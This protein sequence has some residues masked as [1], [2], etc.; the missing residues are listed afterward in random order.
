M[1]CC[2]KRVLVS[3]YTVVSLCFCHHR[4]KGVFV[5]IKYFHVNKI[6]YSSALF[7]WKQALKVWEIY[8]S[9][10]FYIS[11]FKGKETAGDLCL[12]AA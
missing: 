11:A 5:H 12:T 7:A 10:K 2:S 9:Y 1:H 6:E 3:A 4:K 8:T